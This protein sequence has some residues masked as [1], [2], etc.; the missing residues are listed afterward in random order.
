MN[1]NMISNYLKAKV[2]KGISNKKIDVTTKDIRLLSCFGNGED[3]LVCPGLRPSETSP[4]KFICGECG[5]GD[6]PGKYLNED[7][8]AKYAKLD[9]P[10]LSCPRKMPG[11]TDYMPATDEDILQE[12]RKRII[13]ITLG[14]DIVNNQKLIKPTMSEEEIQQAKQRQEA[15][16]K[17]E[18]KEGEPH[19]KDCPKCRAKK[20][21]REK[22][23]KEFEDA[24]EEV[25]F[26]N[27]LFQEKF[28]VVFK[29][30]L[31][32][33]FPSSSQEKDVMDGCEDHYGLYDC[34]KKRLRKRIIDVI[35]ESD[36]TDK[37]KAEFT[38]RWKEGFPHLM[39][40]PIPEN[41]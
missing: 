14:G 11:F 10:Y 36:G 26:E 4:G 15:K 25:N 5:C 1:L 6:G 38:K 3:I 13:E 21:L 19:K 40:T 39:S 16:Q 22:I 34:A 17:A 35:G 12:N 8:D 9:H 24:G 30:R 32:M 31:E 27:K 23:I 7:E 41:D 18:H 28:E 37:W 20:E 29:E 2:S 33:S